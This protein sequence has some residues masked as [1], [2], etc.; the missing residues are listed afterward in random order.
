M[1]RQSAVHKRPVRIIALTN[2]KGGVGKTTTAVNLGAALADAGLRC[3]IVDI[4][5]QGNASTGLG[6]YPENR[7]DTSYDVMVRNAEFQTAI[8]RTAVSNLDLIPSAIDLS[9]LDIELQAAP[10]RAMRL[11]SVLNAG[12]KSEPSYDYVFLDCPP[13]L[14][15]LT[16]NALNCAHALI[17]PLQAEFFALEGLTQLL[18]TVQQI[19]QGNNPDLR[20]SGIVLT[21]YDHR[22]KLSRQVA[23]DVRENLPEIAFETMI[24]RNVRL[25]EAPSHGL[26]AIAYD[27]QCSG[28]RAYANLALEFLRREGYADQS[29]GVTSGS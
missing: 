11:K 16:V 4:D 15:L 7:N 23:E 27:P 14:N 10:D 1:N 5:P 20:I 13:S 28:S 3:L 12:L 2:Q 17:V 26:P 19:Q 18:S 22:N 24:P 6:F 29:Q 9:G 25:S 21:M 8:V